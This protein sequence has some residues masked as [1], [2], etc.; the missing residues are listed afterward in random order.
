MVRV[1]PT[2]D[3]LSIKRRLCAEVDRRAS[4]LTSLSHAIHARPE[5]AFAESWAS[6]ATAT[7]LGAAGFSVTLGAY[8]VPTAFRAATGP[9]GTAT[10]V[11]CCEYDAL[12]G[13]GHA[14]GHNV[15][16]AAGVGAGLALRDLALELRRHL[17]LLGTPAEEQGGGKILLARRGSFRGALAVMLVHPSTEDVVAPALRAALGLEVDFIGRASHAAMAPERGRNAL[18]AAMLAHS[19]I[20][21][22]RAG[23]SFG[24]LVSASL[25][26][27]GPPNV[28][29]A[30]TTLRLVV[31]APTLV[32]ARALRERVVR[33]CTS[34]AVATGC[35]AEI[36][37]VGLPY[38]GLRASNAL[39]VSFAT[40]AS[41]LGRI[42]RWGTT[43][44]LH[45]GG[46]TDL[47][48]ISQVI[49]TIHPMF[50]ISPPT[51]PPHTAGFARSAVGPRADRAIL[52]G[53]KAMAMTV[54][55]IWLRP[56]LR[57]ALEKERRP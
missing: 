17:T 37:P 11:I 52:D 16:A 21:A 12:P 20:A 29:P 51:V 56:A 8:G 1:A 4:E 46:S 10:V 18:D 23:Q 31:R 13:L 36:G 9:E 15:I 14:C 39:A 19:A 45:R 53:A 2:P 41:I 30:R 3:I 34:A 26:S 47:G 55:D 54:A 27:D 24:E 22:L 57:R 6:S 32:A 38:D 42:M 7:T 50:A 40:N 43:A 35:S 49:S 48:N 44:E 33:S 5:T 25:S 28:V